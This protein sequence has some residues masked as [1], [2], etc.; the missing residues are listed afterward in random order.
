[1]IFYGLF[2]V[3]RQN[4]AYLTYIHYGCMYKFRH[5]WTSIWI[6]NLIAV[7]SMD[8]L[9]KPYNFFSLSFSFF[10]FVSK[11][12]GIFHLKQ[13]FLDI[14]VSSSWSWMER[15]EFKYF[16]ISDLNHRYCSLYFD[17]NCFE[18]NKC[19]A[20]MSAKSENKINKANVM[21]SS[22]WTQITSFIEC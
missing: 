2:C 14:K 6:Y 8:T 22:M 20:K 3:L 5:H 4:S 12:S 11:I 15:T 16:V 7:W 9:K 13:V 17:R 21:W 1:M 19:I 10:F 18:T